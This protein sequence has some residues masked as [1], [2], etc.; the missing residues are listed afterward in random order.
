MSVCIIK[1]LKVKTQLFYE[2][3]SIYMTSS[4]IKIKIQK[5]V[6]K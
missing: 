4:G 5:G 6:F 1:N 3:S 2:F